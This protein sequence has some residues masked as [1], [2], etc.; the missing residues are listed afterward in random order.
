MVRRLSRTNSG[1]ARER[2][3]LSLSAS[4][5]A[6]RWALVRCDRSTT[7]PLSGSLSPGIER[8]RL[9]GECFSFNHYIIV[10]IPIAD[11]Y[12]GV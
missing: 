4:R 9:I 12:I 3:A 11:F 1:L 8:G 6:R 7:G 10:R 2:R 5:Y